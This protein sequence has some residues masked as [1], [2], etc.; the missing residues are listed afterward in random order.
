MPSL[1]FSSGRQLQHMVVAAI[2]G[3]L[4][5][6]KQESASI[7]R[8]SASNDKVVSQRGEPILATQQQ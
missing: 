6:Q 7:N 5:T 4:A 3:T 8:N 1:P 2:G